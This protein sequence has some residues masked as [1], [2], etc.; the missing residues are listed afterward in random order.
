M[1]YLKYNGGPVDTLDKSRKLNNRSIE[2]KFS[3]ILKTSRPDKIDS[4]N[5]YFLQTIRENVLADYEKR[6]II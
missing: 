5:F 4:Y 1:S 6:V 3:P 2:M